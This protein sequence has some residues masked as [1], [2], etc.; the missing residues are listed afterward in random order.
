MTL[1]DALTRRDFILYSSA[2]AGGAL[3]RAGGSAAI[4]SNRARA[5]DAL[6]LWY[7]RPAAQWVEA[8]P[9]GNGRLGAMV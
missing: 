2:L 4:S 3:V 9:I 5:I 7:R 6:V 8:L 1:F